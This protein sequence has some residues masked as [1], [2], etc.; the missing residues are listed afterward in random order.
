MADLQ[1]YRYL[2]T[3]SLRIQDKWMKIVREMFFVLDRAFDMYL[4]NLDAIHAEHAAD[5]Y[6]N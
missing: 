5:K 6:S 4:T 3:F 1:I 2:I